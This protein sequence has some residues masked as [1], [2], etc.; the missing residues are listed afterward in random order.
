VRD[1]STGGGGEEGQGLLVLTRPWPSMLRTLYK[2]DERFI[3]TL[4]QALWQETYLW[5]TPRARG[6]GRLPVGDRPHRR[7]RQRLR[8]RLST[9]EVESAIVAHTDVAEA[10]VIRAST[11]RT[12]ARRSSHS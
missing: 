5:E 7:R 12:P 6:Q 9:A 2:E 8:H 1:E 4:L 10:A 11:M 3:E